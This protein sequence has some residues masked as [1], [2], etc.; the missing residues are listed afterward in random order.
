M[1]NTQQRLMKIGI[2][3]AIMLLGVALAFGQQS[4]ATTVSQSDAKQRVEQA[5]GPADNSGTS[6]SISPVTSAPTQPYL[7]SIYRWQ[8]VLADTLDGPR[9]P[10]QSAAAG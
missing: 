7:T 3:L 10:P 1:L 5:Q 2:A 8:G 6:R 9:V 4:S